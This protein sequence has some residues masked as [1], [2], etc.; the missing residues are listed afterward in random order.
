MAVV[1]HNN[2]VVAVQEVPLS[3]PEFEKVSFHVP[4]LSIL[5]FG[6]VVVI[7]NP[8]VGNFSA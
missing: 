8:V 1:V 3:G 6:T 4:D 5:D 7:W 2:V